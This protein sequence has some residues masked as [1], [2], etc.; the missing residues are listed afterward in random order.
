MHGVQHK[1]MGVALGVGVLAFSLLSESNPSLALFMVTTPMGAMLP[2]IDHDSSKIGRTRSKVT[3]LIKVGVTVGIGGFLAF[4]YMSGGMWNA[5]LNG[6]YL[7]VMAVIINIIERNK[8]VKKQ[9]GFITKHRGIMHTLVPTAFLMGTTFWTTNEY[10][11]YAMLG[12]VSGYVVHLLGDMATTEG[13]PIFWPLTKSNIRYLPLNTSKH[14]T[15]IELVCNIWCLLFIGVG[16][17]F[18]M[19]GM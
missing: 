13:A 6:V 17:Y 12:L 5:I 18:G 9:M 15:M 16:I 10:Y 1:R 14:G 2:D 8:H 19:G 3:T 11:F 7:T 4:S